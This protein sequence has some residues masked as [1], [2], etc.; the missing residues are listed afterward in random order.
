MGEEKKQLKPTKL[1]MDT[2]M[3][4]IGIYEITFDKDGIEVE[5]GDR[6]EDGNYARF[7]FKGGGLVDFTCLLMA[8]CIK[9]GHEL[10]EGL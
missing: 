4:E 2:D 3:V 10:E 6:W 9:Y 1:D 5:S 8:I 7:D